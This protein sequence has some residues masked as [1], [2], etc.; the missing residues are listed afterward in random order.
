MMLYGIK[1][2]VLYMV[3]ISMLLC[4]TGCATMVTKQVFPIERVKDIRPGATTKQ[5]VLDWFGPPG[6]VVKK[7]EGVRIFSVIG[8]GREPGELSFDDILGFFPAKHDENHHFVVFRYQY[9]KS[10]VP[11]VAASF[12]H[13]AEEQVTV[14][15]L[16]VLINEDTGIVEDS[17]LLTQES[18]AV[19]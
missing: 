12:V 13:L 16:W 7:G 6:V 10:E 8:D 9:W 17:V 15:S 3:F 5:E 14:S 11:W 18:R 19:R 1:A 4:G 2:D